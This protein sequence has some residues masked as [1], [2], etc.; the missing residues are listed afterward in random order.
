MVMDL[1]AHMANT[2]IIGMLAG[3]WDD[4]MKILTVRVAL[5]CR[6]EPSGD[7]GA[8]HVSVEVESLSQYEVSEWAVKHGMCV[9]GWCVSCFVS[10][11]FSD[12]EKLGSCR[13]HSHP[14][15]KPSPSLKV[16]ASRG[17]AA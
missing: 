16:Q 10:L 6:A 1:H 8:Q 9:V 14:K 17:N 12:V 5:P 15:F 11:F 3:C 4:A 2:E 13:Y 7:R